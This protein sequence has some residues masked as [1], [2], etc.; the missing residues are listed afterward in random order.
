MPNFTTVLCQIFEGGKRQNVLKDHRL[1]E[2]WSLQNINR[3]LKLS[4]S[5]CLAL[6]FALMHS[7]YRPLAGDARSLFKAKLTEVSSFNDLT[8]DVIH[9]IVHLLS[10]TEE[11]LCSPEVSRRVL[12]VAAASS[13]LVVQQFD[14]RT[15]GGEGAGEIDANGVSGSVRQ[16]QTIAK[17][18]RDF[19]FQCS[20]SADS[21]RQ[22]IHRDMQ[23]S[24]LDELQVA[25]LL[26]SFVPH[27]QQA[28][29]L[30]K[31][32]EGA[33]VH[34]LLKDAKCADES[35]KL[36]WW[37]MDVIGAVLKED[38]KSLNWTSVAR[39]IDRASY[40][41]VPTEAEFMLFVKLFTMASGR[42]LPA[43]G[44]MSVWDNRQAQLAYIVHAANAPKQFVD[45][46]E[47]LS[48]V[49]LEGTD[50][51]T[52]PNS[53]WMCVPLYST[54]LAIAARGSAGDVVKILSDA[55]STYPEYVLL[56]LAQVSDQLSGV[57]TEILRR[58]LRYFTGLSGSRPSSNAIMLKLFDI[59]QD[60]LVLLCRIGLKHAQ[61]VQEIIQIDTRLKSMGN[62]AM[63]VQEECNI[64]EILGYWCVLADR[65]QISSLED[66]LRVIL[67]KNPMLARNIVLFAKSHIENLRP[68]NVPDGGVLSF[69]NFNSI[70]QCVQNYPNVVSIQDLR[71]L[72]G[73]AAQKQ[74]QLQSGSRG[75]GEGRGPGQG[76]DPSQYGGEGRTVGAESEEIEEVANSYFQKIYTSDM[77]IEEVIHL[78]K[79]FKASTE[80][81]EQEIFRCMIH[82]LFDEYRFF[83]KYPE[84]ELQVTGRLFGTLIQNQLVSSITLGIALRYVLEALRKDPQQGGSNEKMFRFGKIS[85]EQFRSRLSEWPQY[86]S[87]LVQIPHLANH[88][89]EL[90]REAQRAV[91][92]PAPQGSAPPQDS[93]SS[94]SS[95]SAA[96]V[97]EAEEP[98]RGQNAF[99]PAATYESVP[100]TEV[101]NQAAAAQAS[102]VGGNDA[103]GGRQDV[104][105]DESRR[106]NIERM[107]AIN[108]ES[109]DVQVPTEAARDQILFIVNN[110]AKSN[111]E[112][113]TNELRSVMEE[114]HHNWFANYL[115]VKRVSTQPNLHQTYLAV[116]DLMDSPPLLKA[117]LTSGYHNI[118]KLLQS[119]K[120][121]T[122]SSERSLLRNLGMWLGQL[123]LARNKPILQR[124]CDLKELLLWGYET[125]R[126]IAVCSF[127]A[128][129]VE[130]CKES[131][132]FRPPNPWLMAVLGVM[133]E[134]F[135]VED[136]KMNIKFEVQVLCKNIGVRIEDIPKSDLVARCTPPVKEKN[137]DFNVKSSNQTV[138]PS[139]VS[140]T[141]PPTSAA[142]PLQTSPLPPARPQDIV[143]DAERDSQLQQEQ[144]VIPNLASHIVINPSLYASSASHAALR[145][146]V[147]LAVDRAIREIIQPVVERSVTIACVTT[148]QLISKDFAL[149]PNEMQLRKAAH[150]MVSNLAGSL[151]LVT[152]KEPLRVSIGNHLRSFLA[153]STG[154]DQ[155]VLEQVVQVCSNENLELGCMLIEKAATEKAIRDIDEALAPA[156]QLRRKHSES[157]TPFVDSTALKT[158]KFPPDLPDSMKPSVG[159]LSPAQ[160]LVYDG[161][162]R[163]RS[164]VTPALPPSGGPSQQGHVVS[165]ASPQMAGKPSPQ[166]SPNLQPMSQPAANLSM[167]QALESYQHALSRIDSALKNVLVQAQGR[168]V[169]L[170]MLGGD[171]EILARLR[172]IIHITQC[173]VQGMRM[174]SALTFAESV[175]KR[176]VE[177]VSVNDSLRLEVMVGILEALRDACGGARKFTPDMIAWLSQY[178]TFNLSDEANR[179][180]HRDILTLLMRARLLRAPEVDT[181]FANNLDGGRNMAWVE[182]ALSFIR[183]SLA[184][185]LALTYEFAKVFD[186]VSKMRPS[187]T[188]VRKQLQKWLTD[189]RALASSREE[190]KGP[191]GASGAASAASRDTVREHVMVLL[192]RWLRVWNSSSDQVFGQYLQLLHQ[193]GVLKTE[194]AADRFFRIACEICVEACVK[195]GQNSGDSSTLVYTVIDA[196][197]K[198][199]LLLVRL[200]DKEASD[201]AVRINLLNRILHAI[202]RALVDDHESKKMTASFDQRPYC[203]LFSNLMQD[204]GTVDPKQETTHPAT[205]P[206]LATYCQI[207]LA[208]QPS[209]VPGFCFGWLQLISH[210]SFMP[211]LL[212][213][214]GQKG[215]PYM[216][217][218]LISLLQ[219]LQP[220]LRNAQL[221]DP[222]KRLYKGTLRVLLVLLHDFP[223]FL[224]DYHLSFCEV[225]PYPCVQ[226][227][228]LVLSAFPRS[229]RLPDPFTPNLKVDLLPEISQSPRILTDI[230]TILSDR[231]LKTRLDTFLSSQQSQEFLDQLLTTLTG[232]GGLQVSLMT[233]VVMYVATFAVAQQQQQKTHVPLS[234]AMD[235]YKHLVNNLDAESRYALFNIMANQL[236]YPNNHTHFFSCV[237]LSLFA[238]AEGEFIQE[239]ITRVLLERLIVH[240]PHPVCMFE[241][242]PHVLDC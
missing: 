32:A 79:R 41:F 198:L 218:L 70:L 216:H 221:L 137:P 193:Y 5:Q 122:S 11:D 86:C 1:P 242:P 57:R 85:L 44:L 98:S 29:M 60:L 62:F 146:V 120:I 162:Q 132:V 185:G 26:I 160:A 202:A 92:N 82:N 189:I 19:G 210:K 116:I 231:G 194:E 81:R 51:P 91:S 165:G 211:Q 99:G 55:A 84:K 175:F 204:L 180:L 195:S 106:R 10:T 105:V 212:H 129:T 47:L 163:Q 107:C 48:G 100:L 7:K 28:D 239:Q 128:K 150:L 179:K 215:W 87:H 46:S 83:H 36:L 144:T 234:V 74:Q 167:A 59:N 213:G 235:I 223:E 237:L 226:M 155:N 63:R 75:S 121:T 101:S 6:A 117:V 80:H 88:C 49:N 181:Y 22:V 35:G 178:A 96:A 170:S 229:M 69:E 23:I 183:H 53:S 95:T 149:E 133:R 171:H 18:L 168:D 108:M 199:F 230:V 45:F 73:M 145:R 58:I 182:L 8:D 16:H 56:G 77:S 50:A 13:E 64:D 12:Q 31:S 139:P 17:T 40:L 177:T 200:A 176:L 188:A 126:L 34:S 125:G 118:T 76:G 123:T 20:N 114:S 24:A 158:S 224:C 110:I 214:M 205:L 66:R 67:D 157:G 169:S 103:S 238:D 94:S 152:C 65:G 217:R 30:K 14:Q 43:V 186:I 72:A 192:D 142:T 197:S 166:P 109:Q 3:V 21:F 208:L 140:H 15:R 124:R 241:L 4:P 38:C 232:T 191:G 209:T 27:G 89:P 138:S 61:T 39:G 164:A 206:L 154:V 42:P 196:L 127:V 90:F 227:R 130:G 228:N 225:I 134:L 219:F 68:R 111:V 187:N 52:P 115:I 33:L 104:V 148:Q 222:I 97:P 203:R 102:A 54:L 172:D 174:E 236:R 151:A 37:N 207:Y 78:L 156:I 113:K 25:D 9:A 135:E 159:G 143:L 131:K 190:Q 161:F 153:Q 119:S 220:F 136:L 233:S 112:A 184:E 2:E 201:V 71:A 173:T 147:P 141:S 240:R 93:S